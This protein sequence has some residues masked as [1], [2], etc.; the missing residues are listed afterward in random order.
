[1]IVGPTTRLHHAGQSALE[2]CLHAARNKFEDHAQRTDERDDLRHAPGV[3]AEQI[4][5][6][7]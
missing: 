3:A 1:M 7:L 6:R 2:E 4:K 5:E